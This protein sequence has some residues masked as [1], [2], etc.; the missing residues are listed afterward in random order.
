MSQVEFVAVM[1]T[2]FGKCS[3]EPMVGEGESV[4][5]GRER[6]VRAMED[7]QPVLTLRMNRPGDVKI[8]WRRR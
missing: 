7:S 2:L 6:L 1:A 5:E 8:R 3:A 4:E